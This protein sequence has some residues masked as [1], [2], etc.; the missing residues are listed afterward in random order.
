[1]TMAVLDRVLR[2]VTVTPAGCWEFDGS[3][4]AGG[5]GRAGWN[6]RLW[7]THRLVYT[8][9]VG[10]IPTGLELDHLCK[11][12]PCCNPAHLEP[13]SR[14]ENV[15]RGPAWH[16]LAARE[17]AK[18]HCPE[19]HPYDLLNTYW[20]RRCGRQCKQC[21]RAASLRYAQRNREALAAR[22]RA[23]RERKRATA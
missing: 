21:K 17:V 16:H 14:S 10:E 5:Y 3:R 19:G 18:T 13:V 9:M 1:M 11:N 23:W 12:K 15:R 7:L 4:L 8:L 2:R 20:T 22:S 6:G